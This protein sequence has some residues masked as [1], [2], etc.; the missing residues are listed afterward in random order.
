MP[1]KPKKIKI[2]K[3]KRSLV[4]SISYRLAIM[5]LDFTVLFLFTRRMDVALGFV[6]LSNIYTTIAYFVHERIWSRI[7]WGIG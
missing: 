3:W 1:K 6:V 5:G 4:K 7:N 2:E